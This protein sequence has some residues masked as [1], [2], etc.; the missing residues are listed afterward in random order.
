MMFLRMLLVIPLFFSNLTAQEIDKNMLEE[1]LQKYLRS[2]VS[3]R[4]EILESFTRE[5]IESLLS[6]IRFKYIQENP[7]N[8]IIFALY[9]QLSS[10]KANELAEKRLHRLLTVILLTILLFSFYLTYILFSQ[11]KLLQRIDML[12]ESKKE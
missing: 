4:K 11:R 3:E 8:E 12:T 6:Y 7:E 5:E 10:Y 1:K 9:D 2:G